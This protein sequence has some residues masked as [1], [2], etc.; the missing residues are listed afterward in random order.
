MSR[1]TH[2]GRVGRRGLAAVLLL[3]CAVALAIVPMVGGT[4][5]PD[6]T[7][8]ALTVPAGESV[9]V[10]DAVSEDVIQQTWD[11]M[12][13]ETRQRLGL[14]SIEDLRNLEIQ[15]PVNIPTFDGSPSDAFPIPEPGPGIDR[16]E[17]I[18]PVSGS[19]TGTDLAAM[20]SSSNP[21]QTQPGP[22]L[23]CP[24]LADHMVL[25]RHQRRTDA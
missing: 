12:W 3:A 11:A 6:A 9:R 7:T 4:T 14:T 21:L 10:R 16:I 1:F 23:R 5:P 2:L 24:Q 22:G 15:G 18:V 20:A 19:D 25:R 8:P 17:K 13:P